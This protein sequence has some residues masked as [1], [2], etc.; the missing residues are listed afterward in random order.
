MVDEVRVRSLGASM[1]GAGSAWL[2]DDVTFADAVTVNDA[3]DADAGAN[4]LQNFPV[5]TAVSG[6]FQATLNSTPGTTVPDRV[7]LQYRMRCDR[8][9]R[10]P[11]S[12]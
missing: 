5:L 1:T 4:H 11:R 8:L 2:M 6:G 9:R 10:R 12:F 7:L 3:A